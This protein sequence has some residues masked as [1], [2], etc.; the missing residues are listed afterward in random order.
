MNFSNILN[1]SECLRNLLPT[2]ASKSQLNQ[3]MPILNSILSQSH[4]FQKNN[5]T[6][7]NLSASNTECTIPNLKDQMNY[8]LNNAI[9]DENNCALYKKPNIVDNTGN[10]CDL[11]GDEN[12]VKIGKL[13]DVNI[14][15]N[16]TFEELNF[17]KNTGNLNE[18][19][20][21]RR[22]RLR[23]HPVWNFFKDVE[24]KVSNNYF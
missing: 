15:L 24:D 14:S 2:T 17:L 4:L 5:D 7:D 18:K 12:L 21:Q 6:G 9:V 13:S 20:K 10:L 23:R 19:F 3:T 1:F 16:N 11:D 22:R 8:I